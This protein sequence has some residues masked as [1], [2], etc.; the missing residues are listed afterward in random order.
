M[1]PNISS[2]AVAQKKYYF[3]RGGENAYFYLENNKKILDLSSQTVNLLFGQQNSKIIKEISTQL[4]NYMFSDEDFPSHLNDEAVAELYKNIPSW[5]SLINYRMNDASSAVECAIKMARLYT[6]KPKVV[7]C[8]GIYLGQ[9]LQTISLRGWGER[10]N[11]I[12]IG[13]Q[14]NVIFC[15]K[16]FSIE[17]DSY[18]YIEAVSALKKIISENLNEIACVILDPVMISSGGFSNDNLK[19]FIIETSK[20]C[21]SNNIVYILDESQSYGWVKDNTLTQHWN[22]D[23]DIIILGKGVAGGMPLSIC[24]AREHFNGLIRGDADYTHGGHPLS[25]AALKSVSQLIRDT[26]CEFE[27]LVDDVTTFLSKFSTS[28]NYTVNNEGLIIGIRIHKYNDLIKDS[29]FAKKIAEELLEEGI[30]VRTYQNSIG[31][32]PPRCINYNDL[33]TALKHIFN[34]IDKV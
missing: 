13:T 3:E 11:E 24:A 12:L 10:R 32:K 2:N 5:L 28:L 6:K 9:N 14:E 23:T 33:T 4:N 22:L 29:Y 26:N 8:D 27:K 25:M 31:I 16:P 21:K 18:N 1:L 30:Y 34:K 20:I 7:T 17:N 15:P 19:Q